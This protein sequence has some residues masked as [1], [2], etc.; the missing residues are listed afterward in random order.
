MLGSALS[1]AETEDLREL[2]LSWILLGEVN[3]VSLTWFSTPRPL[4][5]NRPLDNLDDGPL[6]SEKPSVVGASRLG[7]ESRCRLR[8]RLRDLVGASV[9]T[10]VLSSLY[11]SFG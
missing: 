7:I 10:I 2:K 6:C 1:R 11:N 5:L 9:A 8:D 4:S 3:F